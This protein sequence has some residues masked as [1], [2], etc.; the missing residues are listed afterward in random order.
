MC[1]NFSD[2]HIQRVV[3]A[4]ELEESYDIPESTRGST[5]LNLDRRNG[6]PFEHDFAEEKQIM[7]FPQLYSG[8]PCENA[9]LR[10]MRRDLFSC[11]FISI[12]LQVVNPNYGKGFR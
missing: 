1:S 9:D 11:M 12:S 8:P 4:V 2:D 10:L 3:T 6:R 7:F 5:R